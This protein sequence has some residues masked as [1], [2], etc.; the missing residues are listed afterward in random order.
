MTEYLLDDSVKLRNAIFEVVNVF[1]ADP[2]HCQNL[3]KLANML[4]IRIILQD[5]ELYLHKVIDKT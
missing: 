1:L 2:Q 5:I 4:Y 3:E